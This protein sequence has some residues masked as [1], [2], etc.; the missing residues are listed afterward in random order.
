MK[1]GWDFRKGLNIGYLGNGGKIVH[2]CGPWNGLGT[3]GLPRLRPNQLFNFQLV[4]NEYEAYYMVNRKNN[5]VISIAVVNQT[6]STS[7]QLIWVEAE[8]RWQLYTSEPRDLCD[9]YGLCGG[10][11]NCVIDT[12]YSIGN[13]SM[14]LKECRAKYLSNCSCMAYANSDIEGKGS[15]WIMWFGDLIDIR[16][17]SLGGQ[18]L[19]VRMPA[20]EL[21]KSGSKVRAVIV[22]AS[23]GGVCGMLLL[24][25]SFAEQRRKISLA[26]ARWSLKIVSGK[27]NTSFSCQKEDLTLTGHARSVAMHPCRSVM[28]A[29]HVADRPSMSAVFV[30]LSSDCHVLPYPNRPAY[31]METE[32]PQRCPESSLTG[33]IK[34][35]RCGVELLFRQIKGSYATNTTPWVSLV[36]LLSHGSFVNRLTT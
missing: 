24:A 16:K 20:S 27:R 14:N 29:T 17:V 13:R 19:Y 34:E 9:N 32:T 25:T 3:S 33:P 6:T 36:L 12:A 30:M 4:Y 31:F 15:G 18:V 23:V 5:S 35:A 1:L 22:V 28:C 7:Q 11:G 26:L 8:K 10:N 21:G 2:Q